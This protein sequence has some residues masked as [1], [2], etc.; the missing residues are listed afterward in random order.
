MTAD[1]S[2]PSFTRVATGTRDKCFQVWDFD[3]STCEIKAVFS[4]RHGPERD[5]VP[6]ALVFDK[7]PTKDVYVFG[8]YDGGLYKCSGS[9][10]MVISREQLGPQIGNAAMDEER[11]LIVIDNVASGFD[12]YGL[13][14]SA[15]GAKFKFV[16]MLEVGKP[17]KT[18]AKSVV[19]ANASQAV[20][21]GSDHGKVYIFDR[22][23]GRVLKKI[24]HSKSGGVE[25]I[26]VHDD[27]DG[28]VLIASASVRDNFGFA[29]SPIK[30]WRW[31]PKRHEAMANALR[32]NVGFV[33][34][35]TFKMIVMFAA[36]AFAAEH[37]WKIHDKRF[38]DTE[39]PVL[40]LPHLNDHD[41]QDYIRWREQIKSSLDRHVQTMHFASRHESA[42]VLKD[43]IPPGQID[44]LKAIDIIQSEEGIGYAHESSLSTI[45]IDLEKDHQDL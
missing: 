3:S 15:K 18:Y 32:W 33:L 28:S 27:T 34:E 30:L 42:T 31:T 13:E 36:V 37:L 20:I 8:L 12:I 22:K 35:W 2:A 1:I 19:F 14:Q 16:R 43:N 6:K 5:I 25:T 11:S 21:A 41:I 4:R 38:N 29:P 40:H 17:S 23:S 26:A 9:D 39:Q 44:R 7:N 10:G 24:T 45:K